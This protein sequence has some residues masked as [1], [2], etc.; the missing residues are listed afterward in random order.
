SLGQ[1]PV[2]E[3]DDGR[4]LCESMAIC[5]YFEALNPAPPLFG[6][7]AWQQANV[8]MWIRRAEFRLWS[9]M[10]QVWINDD[11]RTARAVPRQFPEYGAHNR[12]LVAA[13]MRWIDAELADGRAFLAGEFSM[14]DIVLV[15]GLDFSKFVRMEMPPECTHLAAW[16]AR[17]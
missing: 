7:S 1:L 16:H 14:A 8:E 12:G 6:A 9:P 11:E 4:M 17:M 5:R 13:A 15:C 10:A 3:T 2:L